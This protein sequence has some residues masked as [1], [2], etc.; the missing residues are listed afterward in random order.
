[1]ISISV[2]VGGLISVRAEGESNLRDAADGP[3]SHQVR[4]R[5]GVQNAGLQICNREQHY[6]QLTRTNKNKI[7]NIYF[8]NMI[9]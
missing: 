2:G 6:Q 4:V 9:Y 3:M 7:L 1:M 8:N 5:R